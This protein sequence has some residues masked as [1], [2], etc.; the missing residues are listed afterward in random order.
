MKKLL[1]A[2][3]VAVSAVA[4]NAATV[5]WGLTDIT[6]SE[7]NTAKA[8]MAAYF[9]LADTY[10]TFTANVTKLAAGDI[11]GTEFVKYVTDNKTYETASQLVTTTRPPSTKINVNQESGSYSAGDT[12]NGYI[13]L[14]DT[15]D[16][17]DAAY[18]AYT[19]TK[20]AT[21]NAAGGNIS[22]AYG[23]FAAGTQGGWTAVPEPTSGLLLL[24]GMAGLA[25][26]RKRA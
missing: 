23:T 13:V 15:A 14:F 19:A 9:L 20:S 22:L 16:A 26:K 25:L 7:A 6:G 24:L 4:L 21:V 11:T 1:M 3:A 18:F 12:V 10:S 5:T 2:F 8:G 17:S